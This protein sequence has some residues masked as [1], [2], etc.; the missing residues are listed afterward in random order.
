MTSM[1][2]G[3]RVFAIAAHSFAFLLIMAALGTLFGMRTTVIDAAPAVAPF[4]WSIETADRATG[5]GFHTAIVLDGSGVP[6]ISYINP[7]E[8]T[9]RIATRSNGNWNSEIVAGPGTF[10]GDTNLMIAA[11]GTIEAS[12][13]NQ[14]TR[15]IEFALKSPGGWRAVRIDSGFPEGYNRL[16]L[17]SLGWPAIAYTAF[18]GSLR[19]AAWNGTRWSVETIDR[20]TITSRYPDLAFDP[21]DR[22]N[23]AYYGNGTLLYARKSNGEWTHVVV[24]PTPNAGLFSR[25][26]IDSRGITHIAYFASSNG[27]LMYATSAVDGWGRQVID[28]DNEAGFDLSLALAPDDRAHIAYY[29]R[30]VGVLRYVAETSQG[31]IRETVDDTGVAGWYTGIAVD[32]IGFPHISYFDWTDDDLRY[33]EGAI[34]LQVRSLAASAI[35]STSA[36]LRGELVALGNH[37][38]A[39]AQFALRVAGGLDWTYLDAGNLTGAGTFLH[40]VTG[41]G[42]DAGYD[43][44]ATARAGNESSHGA[45]R[46]F[47]LSSPASPSP[48]YGVLAAAGAGGAIAV[49]L[50]Y[51][52]YRRRKRRLKIPPRRPF[53]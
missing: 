24:D 41:L 25:I 17:N 5:S 51:G 53:F 36:V 38:L 28:R 30:Q 37:A 47:R 9:V 26:R 2:V 50:G 34:G 40:V 44:F 19:Y 45:I 32:P 16:A 39:S 48:P 10:S 27:S 33:A 20:A 23:I 1:R 12:Y 46:S 11:N 13:F 15:A 21:L 49:V 52:L 43:F 14:G 3:R 7:A 6:R 4:A 42:T 35:N 29:A 18:D 31:W 8:G 22:P